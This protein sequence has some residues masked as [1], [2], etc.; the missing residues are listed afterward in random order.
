[1]NRCAF[2]HGK[3][4]LVRQELHGHQFCTARCKRD[5][6]KQRHENSRVAQWL[7]WMKPGEG[8]PARKVAKR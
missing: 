3:F 4:G 1:M 2:C 7:R 8:A 5:F 6:D